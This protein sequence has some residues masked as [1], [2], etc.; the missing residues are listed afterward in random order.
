[1]KT[2]A[3]SAIRPLA[4]A[5][6]PLAATCV[7]LACSGDL[8]DREEYETKVDVG[9][10]AKGV[11]APQGSGQS[12]PAQPPTTPPVTPPVTPSTPPPTTT[13]PPPATTPVTP[14]PAGGL[15]AACADVETRIFQMR[16]DGGSCHGEPGVPAAVYSDFVNPTNLA[17]AVKDVA[18]KT[19]N[20][21]SMKLVDSANPANSA[22]LKVIMSTPQPCVSFQMPVGDP[23]SA[24]DMACVTE[25]VNAV[26]SGA[27]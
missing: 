23:L 15:S 3:A 14:P 8:A 22:L 25:W 16:C 27:I 24:D 4:L 9:L 10:G 20:C 17:Q 21:S 18:P 12:P 1:M 7:V 2:F 19:T 26:A 6:A 13:P 11:T 5:I